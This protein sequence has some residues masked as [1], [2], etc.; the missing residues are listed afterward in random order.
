MMIINNIVINIIIYNYIY[1]NIYYY[2]IDVS[3]CTY[4]LMQDA[5][6]QDCK[7]LR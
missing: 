2:P 7:V 5:R 1:F 4:T 3:T 6:L